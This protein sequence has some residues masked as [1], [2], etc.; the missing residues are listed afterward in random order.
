[1]KRPIT[2]RGLDKLRK[3]LS[4]LKAMRPRLADDIEEARSHGDLKE[5]AEY[6]AAKEKSG[7]IEAKIRDLETKVSMAE[8][9]DP[10]RMTAG[11]KVVFGVTVLIEELDSGEQKTFSIYGAD[12]TD[13]ERGW[14]SIE[15]PL[16]KGLVG[17]HLGDVARIQLPGG[18]KEFEIVEIRIDYTEQGI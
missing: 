13:V 8:V 11:E 4:E 7:M 17:K 3:E 6:H 2:P 16:G 10:S 9:I 15:S 1:M 12:E 14:V 5:N 18:I